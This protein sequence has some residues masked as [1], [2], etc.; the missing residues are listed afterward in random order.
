MQQATLR[1]D[2]WAS[3][4]AGDIEGRLQTRELLFDGT[5][6]VPNAAAGAGTITAAVLDGRG[7]PIEG[8]GIG[9]LPARQ[10]QRHRPGVALGRRLDAAAGPLGAVCC[11]RCGGHVYTR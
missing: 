11:W 5:D 8:F 4:D 7:H 6:L 2:G 10:R 1:M 9:G 3:L